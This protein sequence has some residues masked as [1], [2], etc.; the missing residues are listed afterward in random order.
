MFIEFIETTESTGAGVVLTQVLAE[1]ADEANTNASEIRYEI[2][3]GNG[4]GEYQITDFA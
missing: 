3:A 4:L 2:T 1:D